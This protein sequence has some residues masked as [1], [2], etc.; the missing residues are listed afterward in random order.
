MFTATRAYPGI[1]LAMLPAD[2]AA[3]ASE[4]T[5]ATTAR[6]CRSWF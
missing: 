4:T 1:A 5:G 3:N 2:D 6:R